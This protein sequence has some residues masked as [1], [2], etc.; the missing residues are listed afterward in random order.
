M[1][2]F[3][4]LKGHAQASQLAGFVRLLI[5]GGGEVVILAPTGGLHDEH[6]A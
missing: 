5:I 4:L 3:L 1:I 6:I 2:Y